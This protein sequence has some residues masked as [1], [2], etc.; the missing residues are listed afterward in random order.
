MPADDGLAGLLVG[1]DAEGRILDGEA[2]ERHAHLVLIGLGACGSIAC[3]MTGSANCMRS[4]R[5][6][7]FSSHSVSPVVV[8]AQADRGGDVA[9]LDAP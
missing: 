9:G 1:V 3:E 4:S 8:D 2:R 7:C 6:G 5:I